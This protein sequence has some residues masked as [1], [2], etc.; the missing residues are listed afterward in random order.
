MKRQIEQ[1]IRA[2]LAILGASEVSFVVE[3]PADFAHGDYATNAALAAYKRLV[4][5]PAG[6]PRD[7][8]EASTKELEGKIDGVKKIE[9]AGPGFINFTLAGLKV[10]DIV[11]EAHEESWG[12]NDL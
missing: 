4:N 9:V 2:A 8:A 7:V 11:H 10:K 3:R 6:G 1:A 5:P 12:T